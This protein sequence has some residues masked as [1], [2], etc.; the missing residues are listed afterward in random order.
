MIQKTVE[1]A[2]KVTRRA[3][4]ILHCQNVSAQRMVSICQEDKEPVGR[5]Y[6]LAKYG[7]I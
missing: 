7:I 2:E 1:I 4:N 3:W 6:S 5:V